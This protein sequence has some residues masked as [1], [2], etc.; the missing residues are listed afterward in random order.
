M[1]RTDMYYHR[2]CLEILNK[3][4]T[5]VRTSDL[6]R[7]LVA[8]QSAQ[9]VWTSRSTLPAGCSAL[10]SICHISRNSELFLSTFPTLLG[11]DM[12]TS[13]SSVIS[14]SVN[15][16]PTFR[17]HGFHSHRE[18]VALRHCVLC[19]WQHHRHRFPGR[20]L[21]WGSAPHST[22]VDKS[23]VF[24]RYSLH[25]RLW[26]VAVTRLRG[27]DNAV[28][29]KLRA[30]TRTCKGHGATIYYEVHILT[31]VTVWLRCVGM[32]QL[33]FWLTDTN[34]SEEPVAPSSDRT[35]CNNFQCTSTS[36]HV[37]MTF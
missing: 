36:P 21:C 11:T 26:S 27:D 30:Q 3:T 12:F 15:P 10:I 32:W 35:D 17:A 19:G 24:Q 5:H 25:Y 14:G 34:V 37:F 4:T 7:R 22:N 29:L 6:Q 18:S 2:T 1:S 33:V 20:H 16:I 8:E 23:R 13:S 28:A 31:A 9:Y